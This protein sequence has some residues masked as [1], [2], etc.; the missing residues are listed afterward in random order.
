MICA[1]KHECVKEGDLILLHGGYKFLTTCYVERGQILINKFGAFRHEN[2]IGVA[3]G[4]LVPNTRNSAKL[5]VL[6][7]TPELW[8]ISLRHRTQ[9]VY[10]MDASVINFRLNIRPG[11]IVVETGTG[12]GS[13]SHHFV[14]SLQPNGHLHTFEFN[15]HRA[16]LA[17]EEFRRHGISQ[18]VTV[19]HA[20]AYEDGFSKEGG[21]IHQ[22]NAV[23][24]DLPMPWKAI[25]H[26]KKA[27]VPNGMICSFSPCV[28]QVGGC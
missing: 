2:M 6:R 8:S 18:Y 24:L 23:F 21:V 22:A 12:S 13:L 5:V 19:H 16:K 28:E 1:Q 9:V 15:Q 27:L 17:E 26:A 10:S 14:R 11:S 20:D 7:A 3:Y 4:Q 25:H